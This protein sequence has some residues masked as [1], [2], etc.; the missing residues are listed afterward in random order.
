MFGVTH[1]SLGGVILDCDETYASFLGVPR[2]DAIGRSVASFTSE[3]GAG[4]PDAMINIVIRTGE[5]MSVRRTF[6][7][8]DGSPSSCV[9]SICLVR[10]EAGQPH[11]VVAVG[12][13]A[14]WE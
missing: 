5:P 8:P 6:R 9:F 10:D 3:R 12:Q 4:G 14:P 11:S 13:V 7:R 2:S 1:V